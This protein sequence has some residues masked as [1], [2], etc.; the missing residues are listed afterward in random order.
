MQEIARSVWLLAASYDITLKFVHIAGQSNH[1]ADLL[2][3]IFESVENFKHAKDQF[4]NF[5]WWQ[6]NGTMFYPN[7]MI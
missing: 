3:R 4:I 7:M 6:V 5:K 1:N 2:S